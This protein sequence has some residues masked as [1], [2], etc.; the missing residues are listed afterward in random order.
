MHDYW[1]KILA[2]TQNRKSFNSELITPIR[3][4]SVRTV[5]CGPSFFPLIYGARAKR[6]GHKQKAKKKTRISNTQDR[7]KEV[8]EIFF[9]IS[10]ETDCS[11]LAGRG[12]TYRRIR[13]AKL[14]NHS[15]RTN[16]IIKKVYRDFRGTITKM[17]TSTNLLFQTLNSLFVC[18]LPGDLCFLE[19]SLRLLRSLTFQLNF[20]AM[21][22]CQFHQPK[23]G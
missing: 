6:A 13:Q 5:S 11:N 16:Y 19:L 3:V 22:A 1:I 21:A 20:L 2:Q 8:S 4:L 23:V 10:E 15:A 12:G 9:D 14:T 18:A 17:K 7:E